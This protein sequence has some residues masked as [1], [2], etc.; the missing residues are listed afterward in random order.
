MSSGSRNRVGFSKK[1]TLRKNLWPPSSVLKSGDRMYFRNVQR[2]YQTT[3]HHFAK[4]VVSNMQRQRRKIRFA[5]YYFRHLT[6][7]Q[8]KQESHKSHND[9][10]IWCDSTQ[11]RVSTRLNLKLHILKKDNFITIITIV[12]AVVS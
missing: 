10:R 3:R 11:S 2:I 12:I 4:T 8:T 1:P 5:F 7:C 6:A 9:H